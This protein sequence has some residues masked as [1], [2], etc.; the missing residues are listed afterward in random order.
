MGGSQTLI[1]THNMMWQSGIDQ[2]GKS[3]R[4]G[5]SGT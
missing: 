3:F 2:S 1:G 4:E 5:R